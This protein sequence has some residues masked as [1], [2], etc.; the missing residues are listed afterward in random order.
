MAKRINFRILLLTFIAVH[1]LSPVYLTDLLQTDIPSHFL[2]SSSAG[3]L[4]LSTSAQWMPDPSLLH[5]KFGIHFLPHMYVLDSITEF[6]VAH[7]THLLKLSYPP[8]ASTATYF[9]LPN[10]F[11]LLAKLC[12]VAYCMSYCCLYWCFTG[13]FVTYSKLYYWCDYLCDI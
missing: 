2:R 13:C 8:T 5:P 1:N 7:K 9:I 11:E 3:L 10:W 4:A 6:K 12:S